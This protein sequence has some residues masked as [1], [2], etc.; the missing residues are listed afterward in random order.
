[1]IWIVI[2]TAL[3]VNL[4]FL[5]GV[6]I[7]VTLSR[8]DSFEKVKRRIKKRSKGLGAV[9]KLS[10]E[11]LANRGSVTEVTEKEVETLLDKIIPDEEKPEEKRKA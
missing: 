1:M 2:V 9:Q 11:Q 4:S 7:T 10:A 3:I 5:L 8:D 6:G